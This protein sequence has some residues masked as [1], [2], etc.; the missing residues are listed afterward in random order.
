M[1]PRATPGANSEDEVCPALHRP[2]A[3]VF[4]GAVRRTFFRP[5]AHV[6]QAHSLCELV[7]FF[8]QTIVAGV[9][10]WETEWRA[11]DSDVGELIQISHA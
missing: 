10:S 3:L 6:E 1:I 11:E 2:A 5:H 7:G 4:T 8:E 9:Y